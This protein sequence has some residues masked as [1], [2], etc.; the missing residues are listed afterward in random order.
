MRLRIAYI[1]RD[2]SPR[3]PAG[4]VTMQIATRLVKK[5]HK[6]ELVIPNVGTSEKYLYAKSGPAL[7][8]ELT[9]SVIGPRLS[10]LV[11]NTV[12]CSFPLFKGIS[13]ALRS[14]VILSQHH[15]SWLL[16]FFT[17]IIS[18]VTRKPL[19]IRSE[20]CIPGTYGEPESTMHKL[21]GVAVQSCNLWAVKRAKLFLVQSEELADWSKQNFRLAK[22]NVAVSHN[23]VDT[24]TFSFQK[25]SKV[26]RQHV[27]S[28]H[29]IIY[30]GTIIRMRALD[31]LLHATTSLRTK[32]PDIKVL[33]MGIGPDLHRIKSLARSLGLE[34]SIEFLGNVDPSLI[35]TY[36]ASA[37]IAIG[38]L[39]SSPQT[40][41][42]NPV[43]VLE[44]MA[45]GAVVVWAKN[46]AASDLLT[47]ENSVVTNST[48][49]G[50][51]T[52]ILTIFSNPKLAEQLRARARETVAEHYEWEKV[53][54]DLLS[55]L[56]SVTENR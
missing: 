31:D 2:F 12:S 1:A 22:E 30:S 24:K 25:R 19:V 6:V 32:I 51:A 16:S 23:G 40:Y 4:L 56:R 9:I 17:A 39:R 34:Q 10:G 5:N 21:L 50:L 55:L 26:L 8:K 43:K 42:S 48:P 44:Y 35:P 28:D 33:I 36:L 7:P 54:V 29:I 3:I 52:T 41:G 27:G 18:L 37:D 13:I 47:S 20:D 49:E 38:L 11:S 14:D 53:I 46:S 15:Y 45:S